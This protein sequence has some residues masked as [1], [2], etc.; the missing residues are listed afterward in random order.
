M[1]LSEHARHQMYEY[2][3]KTQ[4]GEEVTSEMLSHYPSR[5]TD[6]PVTQ[7]TL[8]EELALVRIEWKTEMADLRQELSSD[9]A[10]L[11]QELS[12]EMATLRQDLA[13]DISTLRLE[14]HDG[15]N[16]LRV[17]MHQGFRAQTIWMLATMLTLSGVIIG[18]F[19]TFS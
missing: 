18:S 8:R 4:L 6:E 11:R 9:M 19:A 2:F 5:D 17:E 13:S 7:G 15:L 3:S 16:N 10:T 1:A 14:T 12:A